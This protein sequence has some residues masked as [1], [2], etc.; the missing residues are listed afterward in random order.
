[1]QIKRIGPKSVARLSGF[2]YAVFGLIGGL[3]F[4]LV[5]LVASREESGFGAVAFGI[6]APIVLPILYGLMGYVIGYI[7]AWVYNFAAKRTGGIC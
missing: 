6:A 2:M 5:S 3:F 1:M 7:T 4:L